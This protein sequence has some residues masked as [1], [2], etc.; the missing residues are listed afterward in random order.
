CICVKI[1]ILIN[2]SKVKCKYPIITFLVSKT[3]VANSE[4]I[5]P[6]S[7]VL[8]ISKR[9]NV[10][11][12]VNLVTSEVETVGIVD[13]KANNKSIT[14]IHWPIP[15]IIAIILAGTPRLAHKI[16]ERY[17]GPSAMM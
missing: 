1:K 4:E 12:R 3:S 13:I 11:K 15:P 6:S 8:L 7:I 10:N 2:P 9:E 17:H 5:N 16:E 14:L